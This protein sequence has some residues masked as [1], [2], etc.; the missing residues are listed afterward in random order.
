M[1]PDALGV[2]T[3]TK[4]TQYRVPS[5]RPVLSVHGTSVWTNG[6]G[7]EY[8]VTNPEELTEKV[9]EHVA[10][11][12]RPIPLVTGSGAT[13]AESAIHLDPFGS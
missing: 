8:C 9:S 1:V 2:H 11:L 4:H 7:S 10:Q 12:D 5:N 3:S 13:S 6:S